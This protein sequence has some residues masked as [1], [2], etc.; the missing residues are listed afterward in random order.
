MKYDTSTGG[1]GGE[2]APSSPSRRT[3]I[4][5]DVERKAENILVAQLENGIMNE[6]TVIAAAAI[7][8]GKRL[9]SLDTIGV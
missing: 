5:P 3:P 8:I 9:R 2:V 1:T 7:Y 4:T 6:A